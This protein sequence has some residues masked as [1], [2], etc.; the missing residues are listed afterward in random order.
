VK[1]PDFF[2]GKYTYLSME[3]NTQIFAALKASMI[4]G[5]ISKSIWERPNAQRSKKAIRVI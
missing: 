5:E 4:S 1:I 3:G 2:R